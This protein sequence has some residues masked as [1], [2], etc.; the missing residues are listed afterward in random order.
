MINGIV[1]T[2]GGFAVKDF[3]ACH[4][5]YKIGNVS[6]PS[7]AAA[8]DACCSTHVPASYYGY[9]EP[10]GTAG[11]K[12]DICTWEMFNNMV[13]AGDPRG[14]WDGEKKKWCDVCTRNRGAADDD[15]IALIDALDATY[16]SLRAM[17]R[18]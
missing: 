1:Q 2:E 11:D 12:P 15:E 3:E 16:Q 5:V 13:H 14:V 7:Y 18:Q 17:V 4:E 6:F 9:L 8:L 10:A